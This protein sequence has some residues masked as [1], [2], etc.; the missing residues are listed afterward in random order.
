LRWRCKY[1][2]VFVRER[3]IYSLGCAVATRWDL[4]VVT[5]GEC[6]R[7]TWH[8]FWPCEG[9]FAISQVWLCTGMGR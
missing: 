2:R 8:V 1:V 7:F 9:K 5:T 4:A 6:S 3:R